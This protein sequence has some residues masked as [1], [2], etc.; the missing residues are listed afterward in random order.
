MNRRSSFQDSDFIVA[1]KGEIKAEVLFH[2]V[3]HVPKEAAAGRALAILKPGVPP[4][5]YHKILHR[6]RGRLR[7]TFLFQINS[8]ALRQTPQPAPARSSHAPVIPACF[9]LR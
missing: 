9:H 7:F 4:P 6:S 8:F 2:F 3:L 1:R 5:A